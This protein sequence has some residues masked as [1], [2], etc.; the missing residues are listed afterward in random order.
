MRN[1]EVSFYSEGVK[2]RGALKLPDAAPGGRMP[3]IVQGPGWLGL[4]A[5]RL[6]DRYHA[7]L[8]AAGYAL[9]IIDYRGFGDSEGERGLIYPRWQVEDLR[10][11]L[12]Y[13]ETRPEIDPDRLGAFGSGGSGGGNAVALAATD[14]RVRAAVCQVG[15]ADGEDWLRRMRREY[16]WVE[17]LAALEEDRRQR[18]LTGVSRR[19]S[20]RDEIMIQTPER[21]ETAVKRDVD[22]KL[23][24]LAP[25]ACAQAV[26]ECKPI[27]V[28]DRI[29]PR[30]VM[31]ICVEHDVVTP[32]DHSIRMYERAGPPK[33]L[34][35]Q[36]GTTHYR[37]YQD[38]GAA[39]APMIVEWY[40]RHLRSDPRAAAPPGPA[41]EVVVL[42]RPPPGP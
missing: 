10:N 26:L 15:I 4:R 36:R 3:G 8:T 13:L 20:P 14:P 24:D 11:A 38:Y 31:F 27:E 35:I 32:E 39:V 29:A 30:A 19:V 40:D 37:A 16:E 12:T 6:Y 2:I 28:V 1:E 22:V 7:A 42:D 41:Q 23:Q 9:L 5:A 33:K 34:V 17:F 18:V 25:L 21:R